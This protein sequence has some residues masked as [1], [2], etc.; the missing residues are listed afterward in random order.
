MA[1]ESAKIAIK[2]EAIATA[3]EISAAGGKRT[4]RIDNHLIQ[5][6]T[7]AQSVADS[8]LSDYKMQKVKIS[9]SKP[10]PLP[11]EEGDTIWHSEAVLPYYAAVSALI[12]YA[13]AASGIYNYAD[14]R[15]M[16]IRKIDIGMAG[17]SY[18]G[19][20]ELES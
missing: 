5:D 1:Y 4:L 9:I 16:T 12:N 3:G 13:A 6:T 14:G 11:Y 19:I 10:T 20:L 2:A 17:G 18:V 7:T 8:Y 15:K